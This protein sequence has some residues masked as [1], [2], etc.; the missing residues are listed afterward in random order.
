MPAAQAQAFGSR[1]PL[2]RTTVRHITKC[3]SYIR[4][5]YFVRTNAKQATVVVFAAQR[6][7]TQPLSAQLIIN[8][9]FK[10]NLL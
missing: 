3:R 6:M 10:K 7:I 4:E 2:P 9:L 1:V 8:Q 5:K